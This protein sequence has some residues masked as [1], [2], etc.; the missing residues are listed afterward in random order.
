MGYHYVNTDLLDTTVD[1]LRPEAM[2]YSPDANGS[3]Q[4]GAVEYIVSAAAW[5]AE[6]TEV[7]QVLGQSFHLNERLGVYI[8]HAWLWKNNPSGMFEDWNPEVTC[9]AT[10]TWEGQGRW[11]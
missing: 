9:P 2:V 6:H 10:L 4:L 8:L 11:R 5:D 1:L 7:P 3:I